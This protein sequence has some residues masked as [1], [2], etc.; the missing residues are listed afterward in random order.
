MRE[1][2]FRVWDKVNKSYIIE[3]TFIGIN[4]V[5]VMRGSVLE[6]VS[7]CEIIQ[8]TGLLDGNGKEIYE[9]DIVEF[10][11]RNYEVYYLNGKFMG[12]NEIGIENK[13]Y[14]ILGNIYENSNLLNT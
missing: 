1:I 4:K 9:G 8:F 13:E 12:C 2:K 6:E 3:P 5:F 7:D 10:K 11:G 14:E